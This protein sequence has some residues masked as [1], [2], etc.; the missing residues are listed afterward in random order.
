MG[1]EFGHVGWSVQGVGS[2]LQ[3]GA[4]L[5]VWGGEEGDFSLW[6]PALPV[7]AGNSER[8]Q[9]SKCKHGLL[10]FSFHVLLAC[11]ICFTYLLVDI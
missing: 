7:P 2:T 3:C 1:T 5:A 4:E 8:S 11:F 6:G 9:N 10:I